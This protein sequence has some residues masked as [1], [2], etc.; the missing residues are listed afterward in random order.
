[1]NVLI[2]GANRGLGKALALAFGQKG[3]QVLVGYHQQQDQAEAVV[4]QIQKSGGQAK[5]FGADISQ[6]EQAQSL[7][8]KA[9]DLWGSLDVL[10]NNA[11][12]VKDRTLL[13]MTPEEWRQVI[14]VN[15]TGQF[16]C[17]QAAAQAMVKQKNGS[18]I[19]VVSRAAIKPGLGHGNYVAAKA[20]FLA[21]TK[22]AALE[23]GRFDV[24]VN[25]LVPGFHVTDMSWPVWEKQQ[26]KILAEHLLGRLGNVNE[27]CDLV[28]F[29]A[30]QKSVTGQVFAFESRL[31]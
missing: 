24:R 25:A 2:T 26:E 15:L 18:I 20:G 21:L 12:L 22:A 28:L 29:L 16:W 3:H 19:N 17:L 10:I 31:F 4:A 11:G 5:C 13:K 23:L 1:M 27:L 6:I 9:L 30:Q 14:D 8:N 7:V